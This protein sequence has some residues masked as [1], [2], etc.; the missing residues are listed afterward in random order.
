MDRGTWRAIVHGVAKE[1]NMTSVTKTTTIKI[2]LRPLLGAYANKG[3][4]SLNF[5][6][7]IENP[8]LGGYK[9]LSF[10]LV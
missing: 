10:L 3:S 5:I 2:L 1:S 9:N 7:F 6:S 8:L 4:I